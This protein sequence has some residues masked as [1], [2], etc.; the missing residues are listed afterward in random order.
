MAEFFNELRKMII[1]NVSDDIK[2]ISF[3]YKL[4]TGE[5][6]EYKFVLSEAPEV[7]DPKQRSKR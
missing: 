7:C 6:E 4:H 1:E 3:K 5:T 2:E